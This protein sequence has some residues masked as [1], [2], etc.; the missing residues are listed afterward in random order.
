MTQLGNLH[1]RSGFEY[2]VFGCRNQVDHY[3]SPTVLLSEA[4]CDFISHYLK[5]EPPK[6]AKHFDAFATNR[7]GMNGKPSTDLSYLRL[8]D[9]GIRC[10]TT[11][12]E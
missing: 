4:G 7:A 11:R 5:F 10:H 2:I 9:M 8:P 6:L 12:C 1:M 3:T